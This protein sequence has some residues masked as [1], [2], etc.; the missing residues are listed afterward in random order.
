MCFEIMFGKASAVMER[1]SNGAALSEKSEDNEVGG[2]R[3]RNVA[4]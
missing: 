2:R 4:L 1:E 3:L